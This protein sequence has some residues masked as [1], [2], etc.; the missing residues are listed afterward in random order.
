MVKKAFCCE[1]CGFYSAKWMGRCPE[2]QE[3]NSLVEVKEETHPSKNSRRFLETNAVPIPL[4]RI[5]A[6]QTKRVRVGLEEFDRVLGG[7][8][9]PG[10]V[11]LIC[12]DPGIGKSTLL[13]QICQKLASANQSVLYV[14]GEESIYQIKDRGLRIGSNSEHTYL[15]CESQLESIERHIQ[16]INPRILILDSIQ[17]TY[18]TL[19]PGVPGS[20]GQIREVASR[21]MVRAKSQNISTFLVG[22]VTKDGS[23]AGPRV[24]EHIV[25]TVLYLEGERYHTY[26]ILRTIKN[27]FGPTNEIGVFETKEGGLQEVTNPSA[28]F[29]TEQTLEVS[30]SVVVSSLEGTRPL[31]SELQTL[32]SPGNIGF[33]RRTAIG[34]DSQ[35][36]SLL[37]AVLEKR[38]GLR[39]QDQDVYVNV[40]GGLRL[41]EPAIDLGIAVAIISSLWEKVVNKNVVIIGEV[42]LSG[43]VRGINQP[44][45]RIR[46]ALKLGFD[47]CVLPASDL[48]LLNSKLQKNCHGVRRLQDAIDFLFS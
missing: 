9:V 34:V 12:G 21:I 10:S 33:A 39:F 5:E 6:E 43:E 2:C 45:V 38:I 31:L 3:W 11:V 15:L 48:K 7:G 1:S 32:V 14:S 4:N 25:D 16:D 26:R 20:V 29:L 13:L 35:R 22:H 17:T 8:I 36:V 37:L 19:M 28:L 30:G 44:E 23:I 47:Q 41:N 18:T 42:G 40:V 24:L 46:E 27:R